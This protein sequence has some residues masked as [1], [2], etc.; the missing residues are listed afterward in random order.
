MANFNFFRLLGCVVLTLA[1]G[2]FSG[3]ITAGEVN[4]WFTTINKPSFNP[5]SWVFGPVWTTLYMMMGVAFYLILQKSSSPIKSLT[6]KYFAIQLFFNFW[7]SILFFK[8]HAIGWALIEIVV[9]W[10]F[11]LLTIINAAKISKPA[12][13]LLVPYIAWVSFAT[14]LNAGFWW[15]NK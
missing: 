14:L 10:I 1:V 2:G 7:W 11:I 15:V 12:A 3:Y 5:P 6:I 9:L 13:R 8:F 4:G